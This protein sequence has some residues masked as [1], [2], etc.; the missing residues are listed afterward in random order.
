MSGAVRGVDSDDL[1]AL[2]SA[3][4]IAEEAASA[5]YREWRKVEQAAVAARNQHSDARQI[6]ADFAD[7]IE[8]YRK[9]M[10]H[11]K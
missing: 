10:E 5:T 6:A 7:A 3:Y 2:L 1:P 11:L 8:A 4:Q 9:R